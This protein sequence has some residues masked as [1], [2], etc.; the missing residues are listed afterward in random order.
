MQGVRVITNPYFVVMM[1][2]EVWWILDFQ[3]KFIRIGLAFLGRWMQLLNSVVMAVFLHSICFLCKTCSLE[4]KC[5]FFS[6]GHI[7]LF[8]R[9]KSFIFSHQKRRLLRI[10]N[11]NAWLG[12]YKNWKKRRKQLIKSTGR[13]CLT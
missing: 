3:E 10:I 12:C 4:I 2:K 8:C 7:H 9:S 13:K 6:T 1:R 11:T 5:M